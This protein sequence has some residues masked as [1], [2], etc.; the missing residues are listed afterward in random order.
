M[1]STDER[2]HRQLCAVADRHLMTLSI[3]VLPAHLPRGMSKRKFLELLEEAWHAIEPSLRDGSAPPGLQH[4]CGPCRARRCWAWW[5][6]TRP[7]LTERTTYPAHG[8][9]AN[10]TTALELYRAGELTAQEIADVYAEAERN[11]WP[12]HPCTLIADALRAAGATA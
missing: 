3:G 8:L 2:R 5:R 12:G 1:T 10:A 4:W 7:D 11:P 6:W 9:D